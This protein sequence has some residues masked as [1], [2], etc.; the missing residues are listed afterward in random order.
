MGNILSQK[1]YSCLSEI[2]NIT[3]CPVL[4]LAILLWLEVL[5]RDGEWSPPNTRSLS[6]AQQKVQRKPG[7][8]AW[9]HHAD[10]GTERAKAWTRNMTCS[11]GGQCAGEE[12]K[13]Q[14]VKTPSFLG[15]K[16]IWLWDSLSKN[17]QTSSCKTLVWVKINFEW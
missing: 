15:L 6:I 7:C 2:P 13:S 14:S 8:Y 1:Y 16:Q 4:N 12:K 11:T 10:E 17:K 9:K 3:R 5:F